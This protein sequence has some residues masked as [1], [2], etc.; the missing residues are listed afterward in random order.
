V[1]FWNQEIVPAYEPWAM[2]SAMWVT[3]LLRPTA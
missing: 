2:C 3:A 1:Q